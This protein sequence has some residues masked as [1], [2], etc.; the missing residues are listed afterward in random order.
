MSTETDRL[1]ALLNGSQRAVVFTGAGISTESGIPDF[2]GPNGLWTKIKPIDFQDFISSE[3]VR[4]KSWR[5]WFDHGQ[6]LLDAAPNSGHAAIARLVDEGNVSA[7]ITQNVDNLHQDSGVPEERVIEL[8]GNATYAKC[9]GCQQIVALE[10]VESEYRDS[11]K[12]GPCL[13][14]GGI[15]K[16]ATISFG[17]AMPEGPMR[18][19]EEETLACDLFIVLGSSLTVYPAAGF[20]ALAQQNGSK[21]V[22]VNQ[23]PTDMDPAADLVINAGIGQTMTAVVAS[24]PAGMG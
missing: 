13:H 14:C 9:L 2:R 12:V 1:R 15:V 19:A 22:I 17:Q 20:P 6:G 3:E 18:R 5:Q 24:A 16:T 23:Q 10:A 21:L 8:H 4:Q 7:V 11:G